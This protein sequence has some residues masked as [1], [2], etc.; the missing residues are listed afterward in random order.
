[1][2]IGFTQPLWFY[3]SPVDFRKQIDGLVLLAADKLEKDPTS[4]QLFIFRNRQA[5][6]LKMLWWDQNGFW[7]F[8]KRL[9]KGRFVLPQCCDSALE[10]TKEQFSILLMGLNFID[11]PYLGDVTASNFF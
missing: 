7:L 6:K 1:M 4:G 3:Q 8:Y 5:N 11:Q 9:E 10:I 2:F